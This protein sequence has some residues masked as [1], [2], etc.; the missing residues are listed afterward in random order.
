MSAC[1]TYQELT[2]PK[3]IE[4]FT[5]LF[6]LKAQKKIIDDAIKAKEA[7]YKPMIEQANREALFYTLPSGQ[8]FNIKRSERKGGWKTKDI[9]KLI[10]DAGFIEEDFRNKPSTVF[11]LRV[12][13]GEDDE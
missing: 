7:E 12:E 9:N 2:N 4:V 11:T 5:T 1:D 8:K 10:D 3:M 6:E 13:K